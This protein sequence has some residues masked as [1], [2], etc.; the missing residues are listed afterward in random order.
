MQRVR[1]ALINFFMTYN[2]SKR[3][4]VGSDSENLVLFF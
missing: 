4:T 1:E 2:D 3:D